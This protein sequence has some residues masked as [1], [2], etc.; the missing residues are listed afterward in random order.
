[1]V[2]PD[3]YRVSR[4]RHYSGTYNAGKPDFAH[5]ALTLYGRPFHTV[6][7]S[8][9]LRARG[10]GPLEYTPHNTTCSNVPELTHAWVWA[11]ARSL[12]ATCAISVDFS[13]SGYLDVSVPRVVPPAVCV[14]AGAPGHGPRR[15]AP[16]GDPRV[17][18][19]VPLTAAYRSLP[20]PSSTSCAKASA[21]R[22]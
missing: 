14:R 7:L 8:D 11:V 12:A 6:E 18:G 15:V 21:V 2:P 4:V 17:K 3:S 1:M 13:S 9:Y 22:P 5:G 16:F 20:R 10:A 19:C